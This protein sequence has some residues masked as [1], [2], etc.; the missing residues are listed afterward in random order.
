MNEIKVINSNRA[1]GVFAHVTNGHFVTANAHIN[2]YVGTSDIKHNHAVSIEAA[3]YLAS[4]YNER[5]IEIDTVL[6]LYET[7][8]LG[9]YLAHELASPS[10]LVQN[11]KTDIYVISGEY[12]AQGNIIFRDNL[13]RMIKGKNV[14]LLMSCVTSGKTLEKAI[15][16]V[17]Y[18]NGKVVGISTAFSATK[19]IMGVH[20]NSIFTDEDLEDYEVYDKHNCPLCKQGMPVDAI[21]NGYGYSKL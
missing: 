15:E 19:E 18:Y 14:L 11:P 10:L 2:C 8:A 7:L 5:A 16:S 17:N 9:A 3:K 21:A 13:K 1:H 12:D 20:V 4:Y 6:C